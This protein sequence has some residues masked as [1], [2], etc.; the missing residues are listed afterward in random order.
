MS[1]CVLLFIEVEMVFTSETRR[2][3][4]ANEG[5]RANFR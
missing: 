3:G 4:L 1:T 5:L 2:S